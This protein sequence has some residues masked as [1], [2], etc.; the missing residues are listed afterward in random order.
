MYLISYCVKVQY[1]HKCTSEFFT[2]Y[3]ASLD[4]LVDIM[5]REGA[6]A[7]VLANILHRMDQSLYEF[8]S[9]TPPPS[10]SLLSHFRGQ[11]FLGCA[12]LLIKRAVKD[13]GAWRDT[14]KLAG[15]LFLKAFVEEVVPRH[16]SVGRVRKVIAGHMLLLIAGE[17]SQWLESLLGINMV[18]MNNA[19]FELTDQRNKFNTSCLALH[20]TISS[21][22][23]LPTLAEL[24]VHCP[25]Y[26]MQYSS[27]LH[28][29]VWLLLKYYSTDKV[30]DLTFQLPGAGSVMP[31]E[32]ITQL[33]LDSFLYAVVYSVGLVGEKE[34]ASIPPLPPYPLA[35]RDQHCTEGLVGSS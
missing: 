12:T 15:L 33:D 6:T 21:C 11:L 25:A 3:L 10:Q 30:L 13:H 5:A 9:I 18:K 14:S 23:T 31:T 27:D 22:S 7:S 2:I 28:M 29:L 1:R 32:N 26:I 17:D 8:G 35:C 20:S 34:G 4:R 19:V 24:G 16:S